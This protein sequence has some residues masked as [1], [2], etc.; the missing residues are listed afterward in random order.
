MSDELKN[1]PQLR[2]GLIN[3]VLSEAIFI[4]MDLPLWNSSGTHRELVDDRELLLNI[5]EVVA[6]ISGEARQF[7]TFINKKCFN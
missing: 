6:R 3:E 2:I 1:A 5:A 4:R 7:E